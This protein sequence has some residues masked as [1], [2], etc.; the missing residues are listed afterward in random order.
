MVKP[1][2]QASEGGENVSGMGYW[3]HNCQS[4]GCGEDSQLTFEG[5]KNGAA[6]SIFLRKQKR[7]TCTENCELGNPL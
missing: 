1:I 3:I 5:A 6:T 4:W 2:P 7:R